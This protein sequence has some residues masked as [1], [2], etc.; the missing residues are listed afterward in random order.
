MR[1]C[2]TVIYETITTVCECEGAEGISTYGVRA[3]LQRE[4]MRL[5]VA[6]LEDMTLDE[7]MIADF[8]DLLNDEC[9]SPFLMIRRAEDILGL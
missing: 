2:E 4:D 8:V 6:E 3:Y 7:E 1:V 9:V 5:T